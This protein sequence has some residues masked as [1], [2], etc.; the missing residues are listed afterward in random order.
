VGVVEKTEVDINY[1]TDEDMG[2]AKLTVPI[3]VLSGRTEVGRDEVGE[4]RS[5]RQPTC[6]A[7]SPIHRLVRLTGGSLTLTY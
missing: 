2:G 7:P 5:G 6:H 4:D 1:K 3:S